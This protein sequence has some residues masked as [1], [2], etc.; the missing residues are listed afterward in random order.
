M[1]LRVNTNV[2]SLNA[3]RNL[4][5]INRN[6]NDNFRRL[7]TGLR[8]ATAADDAAGLAISERL[9]A[10][11]RSLGQAKRNANDAISMS[12]TAEGSLNEVSRLE[13][14]ITISAA[15]EHDHR[16]LKLVPRGFPE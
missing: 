7:S 13:V 3:Q 1:G 8:I 6:L 11:I 16:R 9:R 2:A 14:Y 15:G 12:Q 5:N 10:Q 4:A